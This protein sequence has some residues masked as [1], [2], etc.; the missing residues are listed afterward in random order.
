MEKGK[1]WEERER[2]GGDRVREYGGRWPFGPI[3]GDASDSVLGEQVRGV[4]LCYVVAAYID[5]CCVLRQCHSSIVHR[6]VYMTLCQ[7]LSRSSSTIN[8]LCL[9]TRVA[10][11]R[12]CN[13]LMLTN[14]ATSVSSLPVAKRQLTVYLLRDIILLVSSPLSSGFGVFLV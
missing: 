2:E 4:S 5:G 10:A 13:T 9:S 8:F 3:A 14:I 6:L 7:S 11:N 12:I 1:A